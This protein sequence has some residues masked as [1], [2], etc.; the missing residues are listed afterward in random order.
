M[1]IIGHRTVSILYH[2]DINRTIAVALIQNL[3]YCVNN[4]LIIDIRR[5]SNSWLFR[6]ARQFVRIDKLS[7]FGNSGRKII[8]CGMKAQILLKFYV[9]YPIHE[10]SSQKR[11]G[12]G[13]LNV[14]FRPSLPM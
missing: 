2:V 3:T 5:R 11:V 10:F 9:S 1:P 14:S 8:I 6:S 4:R 13:R 12:L 7:G